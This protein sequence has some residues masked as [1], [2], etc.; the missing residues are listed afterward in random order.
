[1]QLYCVCVCALCSFT[2]TRTCCVKHVFCYETSDCFIPKLGG[3]EKF[4]MSFGIQTIQGPQVL[5]SCK[6]E[7]TLYLLSFNNNFQKIRHNL[8]KHTIRR[9]YCP[10]TERANGRYLDLVNVM[11]GK[12]CRVHE[13]AEGLQ[14]YS[15]TISLTL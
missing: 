13:G 4:F 8:C 9:I 14:S 10:K 1:M 5:N 7:L 11:N 2:Q 15:S 12:A 6:D 3:N